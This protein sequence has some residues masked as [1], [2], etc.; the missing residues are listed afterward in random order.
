[1][2]CLSTLYAIDRN[3]RTSM[4]SDFSPVAEE[5]EEDVLEEEEVVQ[6]PDDQP[7][8]ECPDDR[9]ATGTLREAA[10]MMTA[11]TSSFDVA[12]TCQLHMLAK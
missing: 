6:A 7:A 11:D 2:L 9:G 10:H 8:Y 5:E 1:M 12:G 4:T 3:C